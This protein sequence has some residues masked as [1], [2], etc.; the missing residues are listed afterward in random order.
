MRRPSEGVVGEA[1][2]ARKPE[3]NCGIPRT[4]FFVS[5]T[6]VLSKVMGSGKKGGTWRRSEKQTLGISVESP[7]VPFT[8]S[9]FD[10]VC[11]IGQKKRS[12][13][14]RS[15]NCSKGMFGN[16]LARKKLFCGV[17]V[18]RLKYSRPGS[19]AARGV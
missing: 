6:V 10:N 18:R 13:S 16:Y 7:L 9:A 3:L 19:W 5:A 1:H 2:R 4:A 14:V 15:R 17:P 11:G 12:D 8:V